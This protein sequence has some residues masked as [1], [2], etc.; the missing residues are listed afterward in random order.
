MARG[1]GFN[2]R[3]APLSRWFREVWLRTSVECP[4]TDTLSPLEIWIVWN[5]ISTAVQ[6]GVAS[7][8]VAGHLHGT[9]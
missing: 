2:I 3:M 8:T 4:F 5:R 1:P 6:G 7:R 9:G